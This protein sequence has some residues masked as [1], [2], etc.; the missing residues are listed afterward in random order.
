MCSCSHQPRG[1]VLLQALHYRGFHDFSRMFLFEIRRE[2]G[3]VA[4]VNCI[5]GAFNAW[6]GEPMR[7]HSETLKRCWKGR[8][9]STTSFS[10]EGQC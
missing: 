7:R 1:M 3:K 8:M 4:G 9:K 10:Y 5:S 6:F 2:G